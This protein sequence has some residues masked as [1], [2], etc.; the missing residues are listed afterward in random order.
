MSEYKM[1]YVYANG[2]V[3]WI[4]SQGK[5]VVPNNAVPSGTTFKVTGA[6]QSATVK[7]DDSTLED[8]TVA[9]GQTLD[10]TDQVLAEAMGTNRAGEYIYARGYYDIEDSHGNTG[11]LYQIRVTPWDHSGNLPLATHTTYWAFSGNIAVHPDITYT[12]HGKVETDGTIALN[13]GGN[14]GYDTYT[15]PRCFTAGTLI[16]TDDGP[17]RVEELRVGD[18]VRTRD[19]GLKP[20]LWI[21][22]QELDGAL[23]AKMPHLR[24]IRIRASALGAGLPRRDLLLSRQHRVVIRNRVVERMFG[25]TEVLASVKDLLDMPGIETIED[26]QGVTYYHFLLDRHEVVF[27]EGVESETLYTGPEALKTLTPE[28][29]REVLSLFPQLATLDPST[30]PQ[31]AGTFAEGRRARRMV[32]RVVRNSIDLLAV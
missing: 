14:K 18:L 27:A 1:N 9:W 19:H 28:A 32:E 21:E 3:T 2:S 4:S 15:Q 22:S 8:S 17:V 23:L 11:R 5:A 16:E 26:A 7:D 12:V 31:R 24:P 30:L 13:A 20:V 10:H 25:E 29:R 6:G